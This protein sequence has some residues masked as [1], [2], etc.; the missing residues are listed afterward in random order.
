[1]KKVLLLFSFFAFSTMVVF[2]VTA[3]EQKAYDAFML[4]LKA[5]TPTTA[6]LFDGKH[7]V[8]GY[9]QAC[10]YKV[11]YKTGETYTCKFPTPVAEMFGYQSTVALRNGEKSSFVNAMLNNSNYCQKQ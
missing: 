4:K 1:M 3:E 10:G 7:Q 8:Y 9:N 6:T 11:E 5:C 2:A